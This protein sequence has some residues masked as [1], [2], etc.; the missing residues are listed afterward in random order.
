MKPRSPSAVPLLAIPFIIGFVAAVASG[1]FTRLIVPGLIIVV[2]LLILRA[3]YRLFFSRPQ[4]T[5]EPLFSH[6]PTFDPMAGQVT[7][8]TNRQVRL[9][10]VVGTVFTI[11]ARTSGLYHVQQIDP[12]SGRNIGRP[13][14]GNGKQVSMS[15]KQRSPRPR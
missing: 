7:H 9:V 11:F 6:D 10:T 12:I 8:I 3:V 13:F 4:N 14:E 2:S 1:G 15:I 5:S